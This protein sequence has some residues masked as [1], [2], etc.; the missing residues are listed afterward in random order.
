MKKYKCKR[1]NHEWYP[2]KPS[3]PI[4][5]PNCKSAYWDKT[6]LNEEKN[7]QNKR[8]DSFTN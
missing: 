5:C 7:E 6:R 3:K 2:R 8:A 4:T 1:C